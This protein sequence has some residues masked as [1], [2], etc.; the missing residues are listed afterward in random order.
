M[1]SG[2]RLTQRDF[3]ARA[4]KVHGKKYG[5]RKTQFTTAN[6]KVTVTC[7]THGDF[8]IRARNHM[9]GAGCRECANEA[10]RGRQEPRITRGEF[11]KRCSDK[12]G[13]KYHYGKSV[14]NGTQ[15]QI[16]I[17]CP[18]HGD[19]EQKAAAHLL[20][21]GCKRCACEET[22]AALRRP[23]AEVKR[24]LKTLHPTLRFPEPHN[25]YTRKIKFICK[26]HGE[27]EMKLGNLLSGQ[28]CKRCG[29]ENRGTAQALTTAEFVKRAK[30]LYGNRYDYS[31]VNYVNAHTPVTIICPEHGEFKRT[32]NGHL[33]A[34]RIECPYCMRRTKQHKVGKKSFSVLSKAEAKALD[35]IFANTSIKPEHI[36]DRCNGNV[37]IIRG[38]FEGLKRYLPDF[39]VPNKNLVIEV[40]TP[41][42]F[43]VGRK[44]YSP[45]LVLIRRMQKR[46]VATVE[47]G[48]TFRLYVIAGSR[49]LKLPKDWMFE[50]P[51]RLRQLFDKSRQA[52]VKKI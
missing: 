1:T 38:S 27:S 23:V 15:H 42:S 24:D 2:I 18:K 20:G 11:I 50:D 13:N 26:T 29:D 25:V 30:T 37:P 49:K 36:F 52:F 31:K 12:H 14:W 16:I 40:K 48:Y 51:K 41:E 21:K 44:F 3:V 46:A 34:R 19:F 45:N 35:W 32:G 47:A 9:N 7:K 39:F 8:Q 33:S 28:G 5:Y 10:M 17:T 22:N 4:T 6:E 43:G